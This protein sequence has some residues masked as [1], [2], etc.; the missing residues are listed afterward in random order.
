MDVIELW[1]GRYACALQAAL[2]LTNE[3]F[4]SRLGVAPRTVATWH[5]DAEVI[6]RAD[7][8]QLLDSALEAAP[9]AARHRFARLVEGAGD[10]RGTPP[11]AVPAQALRVAIAVVVR[12]DQ[13][14]L[15]CRRDDGAPGPTWQ[16][17]AGVVKPGT[18][19]EATTVRE[20]LDETGVHCTVR[21]PLG[22]RL[23]PLTGVHCTYFLCE[24]LAGEA[25]NRDT[26][27]NLDVT[28]VPRNALTRFIPTDTVFPPILAALEEST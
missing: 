23:H 11:A 7:I 9:E 10:S 14:L 16:F 25:T 19:P 4:A 27:E 24:Y 22:E 3:A 1:N 5:A 21:R 26:I 20:T 28:W 18:R 15:V 8:Q 12:D 6:P 13:V 17:P 2:R